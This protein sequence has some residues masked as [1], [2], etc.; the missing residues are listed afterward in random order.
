M[1]IAKKLRSLIPIFTVTMLALITVSLFPSAS[2]AVEITV[3]GTL[4]KIRTTK[5]T[6]R[7]LGHQLQP[8]ELTILFGIFCQFLFFQKKS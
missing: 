7:K 1:K 2:K 3:S 5:R 8:L 6:N 4:S